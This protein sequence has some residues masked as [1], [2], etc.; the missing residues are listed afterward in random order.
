MKGHQERKNR[1]AKLHE[2]MI[3]GMRSSHCY[4]LLNL[5][6]VGNGYM[7]W[8][9]Y[10]TIGPINACIMHWEYSILLHHI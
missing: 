7:G 3:S 6:S 10:T 4:R 2:A 8:S 9:G 5:A 1:K